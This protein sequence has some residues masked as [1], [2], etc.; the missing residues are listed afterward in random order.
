MHK[1]K[2]GR[3]FLY[4]GSDRSYSLS[5]SRLKL[6][7]HSYAQHEAIIFQWDCRIDI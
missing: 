6:A 3:L 7:M 4:E 1:L 5:I 2:D